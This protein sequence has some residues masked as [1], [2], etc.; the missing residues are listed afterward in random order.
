MDAVSDLP[1]APR[2]RIRIGDVLG[3][4]LRAT[5]ANLPAYIGIAF[6]AGLATILVTAAIFGTDFIE[7]AAGG[8]PGEVEFAAADILLIV[9]GLFTNTLVQIAIIGHLAALMAGQ[10]VSLLTAL[11]GG[12]PSFW[13]LL[14]AGLLFWLGLLIGSVLLIVP[15]LIFA[16]CYAV[17]GPAVVLDRAGVIGSFTRSRY[18]TSGNR[19][20]ILG[21]FLLVMAITVG[22]SMVVAIPVGLIAVYAADG[23]LA[24]GFSMTVVNML[25]NSFALVFAICTQTVL[26]RD[27][28]I[29]REGEGIADVGRAFD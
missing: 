18:L 13:A 25:V 19:W 9:L 29:I 12:L 20:R 23:G 22:I 16:A 1:P 28:R 14:F 21:V 27:L 24:T 7:A 6:A 4:G 26:H 3:R 8:D 11:R 17:I 2:P 15:G 10:P 5:F